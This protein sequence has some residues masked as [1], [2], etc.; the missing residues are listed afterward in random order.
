MMPPHLDQVVFVPE[1]KQSQHCHN[2][3]LKRE[4]EEV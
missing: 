2:I 4:H 3:T 1:H